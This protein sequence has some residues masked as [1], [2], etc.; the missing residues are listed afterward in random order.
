VAAQNAAALSDVSSGLIALHPPAGD[1]IELYFR[2]KSASGARVRPAQY[3]AEIHLANGKKLTAGATGEEMI[4]PLYAPLGRDDY[5][6]LRGAGDLSLKV[7]LTS[8]ALPGRP[9]WMLFDVAKINGDAEFA[10]KH[11]K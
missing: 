4:D 5:C 2:L 6:A 7:A 3:T 9:R 10:A 8:T 11:C 1:A